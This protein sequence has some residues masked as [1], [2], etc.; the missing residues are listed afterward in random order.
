MAIVYLAPLAV[1]LLA[2]PFLG[3]RV[4]LA[5]WLGAITG[6]TGVLLIVRPGSG[7]DPVGVLC[8]T[9]NAGVATA[10]H[11]LTRLLSR[12]EQTIPL[13]F[14]TAWVGTFVFCVLA[15]P[16][17]GQVFAATPADTGLMVLLGTLMTV[18]HFLFTAAY[19]MAPASLLAPVNTCI[20]SSPDCS[21]G[22]CSATFPSIGASSVWRS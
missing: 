5:G 20:W 17:F 1:M 6:F 10:Y 12:T 3:E 2:G 21:V 11:L 19:R 14:H 18:G 22:S 15:I 8:A 4:R 7:L 16:H 13:L 9:V